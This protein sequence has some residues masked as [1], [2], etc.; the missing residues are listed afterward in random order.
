L[1]GV[2]VV[3]TTGA[4]DAM[5]AALTAALLRGRGFAQAAQDA[6]DAAAASVGRIGGRP[7]LPDNGV[8]TG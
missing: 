5:I 8:T 3:D 1:S 7:A 2:D 4:G 6:S